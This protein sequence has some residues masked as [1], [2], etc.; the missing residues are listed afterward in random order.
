MFVD[1]WNA[2]NTI[3][4]GIISNTY[5]FWVKQSDWFPYATITPANTNINWFTTQ[6]DI[7]EIWY[8]ITVYVR[9]DWIATNEW[10]LR[11][12]VD[13]IL[14]ALRPQFTLWWIALSAKREVERGYM[15][16]QE[17]LRVAVIKCFYS[18]CKIL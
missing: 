6:S 2:L 7:L 1:V 12:K 4:S 9:N 17:P 13:E 14:N 18:I 11:W 5:N 8:D 15:S 3:V 10:I 16:D